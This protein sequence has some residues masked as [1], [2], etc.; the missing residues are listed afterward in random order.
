MVDSIKMN[1]ETLEN[2]EG[3]IDPVS[4]SAR[5]LNLIFDMPVERQLK[6]LEL[7]D[8]WK[9]N[10][11]RKHPRKKL[12]I[13]VNL[14]IER[15]IF[16]ESTKDISKGGLYIETQTPF[17]INQEVKLNIQLPNRSNPIEIFGEIARATPQG[18]G[19]KFKR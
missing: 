17:S 11:V 10:G 15:H 13:P 7:L 6:L 2:P 5:L 3:S 4:I 9:Y 12:A 8:K 1:S 18:I 19:I 16:K 14:E